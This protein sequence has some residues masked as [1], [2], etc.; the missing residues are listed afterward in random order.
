MIEA[1]FETLFLNM[2][3]SFSLIAAIAEVL[4]WDADSAWFAV[5]CAAE[6]AEEA[7]AAALLA[8]AA[9]LEAFA[10]SP[11]SLLTCDFRSSIWVC[12]FVVSAQPARAA[13]QAAAA[14]TFMVVANFISF[15]LG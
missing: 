5:L 9:A 4:D 12:S 6:A 14:A 10:V 8:A 11:C 1:Y 7:E 15:P 3:S 2:R 13:M